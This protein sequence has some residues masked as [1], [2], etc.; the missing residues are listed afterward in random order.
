MKSKHLMIVL[1][2]LM[3]CVTAVVVT[4]LATGHVEILEKLGSSMG[5]AI[6]SIIGL[7][8]LFVMIGLTMM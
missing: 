2:V 6:F 4:T 3:L 1:L 7:L 5:A 8:L